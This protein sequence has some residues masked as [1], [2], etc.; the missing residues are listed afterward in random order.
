MAKV[1]GTCDPRFEEVRRLL[2]ENVESGEELGASIAINIDGKLVVDM[3]AG[4]ADEDRSRLWERDTIVNVWSCTKTVLSLAV[5]M[6]VD[7][8]RVDVDEKVS[9]YWPEFGYNGKG[10]VLVRHLLSHTSG[11]SG[12][13]E[14]VT[15]QHLYDFDASAARLGKQAP[16]WTP[17]TASGYQSLTM[18]FLLGELIRRVTGK[19]FK[20]FVADEIAA[21]L[22]ADF[23]VGA[24]EKDLQRVTDIVP[25]KSPID[26]SNIEP[27]S[28]AM[29]TFHRPL[30]KPE[31]ANAA[32]WRKA[33]LGAS[34]G[35]GNARSLVR[36][37]SA[38]T[39]GGEVDGKRLLSEKTINL[40]GREQA[41]GQDLVLGLPIRWAIGFAMTPSGVHTFL[42]QDEGGRVYFWG[43]W[44]G[45]WIVMDLDRRTTISYVMNKMGDG[46]GGNSR[47]QAYGEAI[48]RA[49]SKACNGSRA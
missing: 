46:V 23:Q 10:D 5:L 29:K 3:W 22:D 1:S 21:P 33:D 12:F 4:Y 17:G 41:N 19:S 39:L 26:F 40:I 48:Y 47:G 36:I 6:L 27:D 15:A 45:S 31:V 11:L 30:L 28:I 25:S 13:K 14:H 38:V 16:W 8:G 18:G 9:K 2:G 24:A 20:Q 49:M 34:N 42:P 44:G 35:H 32:D 43:G 7:Q 37:L